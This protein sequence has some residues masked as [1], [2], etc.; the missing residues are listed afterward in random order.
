MKRVP[1]RARLAQVRWA[2]VLLQG[3]VPPSRH[4]GGGAG[5]GGGWLFPS[6]LCSAQTERY[7]EVLISATPK[8]RPQCGR[9]KHEESLCRRGPLGSPGRALPTSSSLAPGTPRPTRCI[10]PT[11]CPGGR[12]FAAPRA[13]RRAHCSREQPRGWALGAQ[14]CQRPPVPG[15]TVVG[16]SPA[17]APP[18]MRRPSSL[19]CDRPRLVSS[20]PGHVNWEQISPSDAT[21]SLFV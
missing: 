10:A 14:V 15:P 20:R 3:P 2:R 8:S 1:P 19:H 21:L 6:A 9:G 18:E 12:C 5:G 7:G 11:S 4:W 17:A 13:T 16:Q